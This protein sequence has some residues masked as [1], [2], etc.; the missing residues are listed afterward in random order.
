MNLSVLLIKFFSTIYSLRVPTASSS[1]S[2]SSS[3]RITTRA[4]ISRGN[5]DQ[6]KSY[7]R[8]V[9]LVSFV[10]QRINRAFLLVSFVPFSL[11]TLQ[12]SRSPL[13]LL[14]GS[15][16]ALSW[17]WLFK[18]VPFARWSRERRLSGRVH[19]S[20]IWISNVRGRRTGIDSWG[21]M[22]ITRPISLCPGSALSPSSSARF[23]FFLPLLPSLS[24]KNVS[25]YLPINLPVSICNDS[26][27][28][29]VA[30]RKCKVNLTEVSNF[31]HVSD[32]RTYYSFWKFQHGTNYKIELIFYIFL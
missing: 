20:I 1:P 12:A 26:L 27:I 2:R 31:K 32:V 19:C 17:L 13:S 14:S 23:L 8:A 3:L 22:G 4:S 28:K 9:P 24:F 5:N 11:A 18:F 21:L 7:R 29:T 15:S 16:G 25:R 6:R 10:T 30:K